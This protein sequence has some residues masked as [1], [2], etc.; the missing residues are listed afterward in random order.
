MGGGL[1]DELKQATFSIGL[2][3]VKPDDVPKV[4]ELAVSTLKEAAS[5]GFEADAIEA[6]LNTIEFSLREFNTGGFP[7]GL[8][9]MLAVMPR[10]LYGRGSPTDALRFEE[11]LTKLKARLDAGEKVFEEL[12]ERMI[13]K[14][15]HVAT[16]ELVP[17]TSLAKQQLEAEAA[18]LAKVKETMSEDEIMGVIESTKALKEAQLKEDSEQD[19]AS[20]PRVGLA[21]LERKVKTIPTEQSSLEGGGTLLSHPLPTAGVVYTDILLDLEPLTIDEIPLVSLMTQLFTQGGTSELDAVALQRRIGARTGG[22]SFS[23]LTT[24]EVGEHGMMSPAD[25]MAAVHRLAI[26]A[27]GT[28]EK[29][30]DM[31]DLVHQMLSDAQFDAQPKVV[32]LLTETKSR[33]ESG[34]VS[35]GNS[36]A[37]SRLAARRSAVGALGE[38]TGGVTYYETA[39]ELLQQAE[40]DWP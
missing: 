11:P 4:E 37:G 26:R 8:S 28:V 30:R 14:N 16:V 20:I 12:L 34:F 9:V 15:Q 25:P 5:E 19:L 13:V 36:F 27:K 18:E 33:F 31:F 22:I 35:S 6:S 39:K 40:S 21:D 1:S 29:A 3:G 17:D 7:R 38:I 24:Q 23:T 10:W 32:E 2:K